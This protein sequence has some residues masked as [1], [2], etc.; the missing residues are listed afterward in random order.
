M[1]FI[2]AGTLKE[3]PKINFSFIPISARTKFEQAREEQEAVR[4]VL[5]ALNVWAY[6]DSQGD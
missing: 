3:I 5:R 1:N 4:V 2:P 6:S